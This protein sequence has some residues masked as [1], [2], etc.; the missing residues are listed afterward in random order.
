MHVLAV[1]PAQL[2]F[3]ATS[4]KEQDGTRRESSQPHTEHALGGWLPSLDRTGSPH[5]AAN[6]PQKQKRSK[7]C[8]PFF[9]TAAPPS[10]DIGIIADHYRANTSHERI[11][12]PLYGEKLLLSRR[13]DIEWGETYRRTGHASAR[14]SFAAHQSSLAPLP[15]RPRAL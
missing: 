8:G 4:Y 14:A 13:P 2:L 11:V 10:V 7:Q 6:D 5:C 3:L 12:C 9:P 1:S 15:K